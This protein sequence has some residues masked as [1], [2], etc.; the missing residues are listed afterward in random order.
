MTDDASSS[1]S[2]FLDFDWRQG[3]ADSRVIE[4]GRAGL[5]HANN[6]DEEGGNVE[7]D[8][9]DAN[10]DDDESGGGNDE[11]DEDD[12]GAIR[13]G[14][15]GRRQRDVDEE[16]F[17]PGARRRRL[18]GVIVLGR[19]E[20]QRRSPRQRARER[21]DLATWEASRNQ[22]DYTL[23]VGD[24]IQYRPRTVGNLPPPASHCIVKRIRYSMVD[25]EPEVSTHPM[26]VLDPDDD[27]F[28]NFRTVGVDNEYG[29]WR[30]SLSVNLPSGDQ[31]VQS[32]PQATMNRLN[33]LNANE[34][35]IAMGDVA[36]LNAIGR[37][38]NNLRNEGRGEE[39]EGS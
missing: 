7:E 13:R 29:A 11:E 30:S 38:H 10:N 3:V 16:Y 6:D 20:P 26:S 23:R 8:E 36:L 28:F 22:H 5:P 34:G 37:V 4:H 1:D 17:P 9:D 27:G 32:F 33:S 2:S 25:R 35:G 18:E 19:P 31:H 14:N 24:I 12:D 15:M 21:N 39:S